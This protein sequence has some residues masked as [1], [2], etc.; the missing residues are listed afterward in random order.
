MALKDRLLRMIRADGPMPVSLYMQT[1]LHDPKEGY[2]ATRPGLGEDFTTAPEIS[3][4]FGEL[5]GLWVV[6]EWI[7]LGRPAPFS[8]IEPGPG[9]ATLMVD[10]L[11]AMAQN[12][13]GRAC[14]EAMELYLIEAS[15]ALRKIQTERLAEH[16]PKYLSVLDELPD[17]PALIVANEF[18]DCLP[19][20]QFVEADSNKWH[21]RKVGAKDDELIW[22]IDKSDDN[23]PQFDQHDQTGVE[24]QPGLETFALSLA[25][26][27]KKA[28]PLRALIFDYGPDDHPAEDT[29]RAFRLGKQVDPLAAPGECDLT[30]DVD[31]SELRRQAEKAGLVVYGA[32]TQS[33]FLLALGAELRMQQLVK[34]HPDRAQEIFESAKRLVDP[35]DL[36]T[37]F[38]AICLSSEGL[39]TPAGF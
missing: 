23:T 9:R 28:Q 31:F 14:L 32:V 29:L 4:I 11:R 17:Q 38:K 36:G 13:D 33:A 1:C 19:V 39:G 35:A 8:L 10:A 25:A 22:A 27:L 7:G 30:V 18:L 15:P 34:A 26:H 37:R 21:E 16:A 3:Q 20:R 6:H 2:Y 12:S 5:I 24:L